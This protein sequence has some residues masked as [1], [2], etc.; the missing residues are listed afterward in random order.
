MGTSPISTYSFLLLVLPLICYLKG[1]GGESIYGRTFRDE[2]FKLRHDRPMLLSMAKTIAPH[3]AGSQF[4][5]TFAPC[6]WLDGQHVVFGR[7][8][9]VRFHAAIVL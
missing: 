8:E 7:V 2:N 9:Q 4:F 5:I 6:D 1:R 3:T